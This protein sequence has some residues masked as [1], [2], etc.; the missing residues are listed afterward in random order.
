MSSKKFQQTAQYTASQ[1]RVSSFAAHNTTLA[2][3]QLH[4]GWCPPH[5]TF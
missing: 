1:D 4:T 2:A 5:G 3:M